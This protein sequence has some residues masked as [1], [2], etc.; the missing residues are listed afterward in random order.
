MRMIIRNPGIGVKVMPGTG[1]TCRQVEVLC[2]LACGLTSG[3]VAEQLRISEHTVVRHV[4][5]MTS[6]F[7]AKNRMEL[8]ALAIAF[9]IIDTTYWP[10]RPSGQMPPSTPSILAR[11]NR[12][13]KEISSTMDS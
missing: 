3:A 10:F 1:V 9:G 12:Q 6:A 2:F 11:R 4:S 5:N 13:G 7:G 8:L